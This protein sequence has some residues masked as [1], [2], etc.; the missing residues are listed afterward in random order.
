[1]LVSIVIPAINESKYIRRCLDAVM[2]QQL[3]GLTTEIVVVDGGSS[4]STREI[5]V[6]YGVRVLVQSRRGIAQARQM[7]FQAARG[8]IIA[9]TDADSEPPLDWLSRLVGELL[10]DSELVGVY[11]PIRLYDGKKYEDVLSHY[12]AGSYLYLN[13]VIQRPAFS[14]QNFAVWRDAW[15]QVGGFDVDWVSAEDVNLSLKLARIGKVKFC[16][17]IQVATSARRVREGYASVVRHTLTNYTRVTWLHKPP[18]PFVD[19]R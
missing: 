1:M 2:Q 4:D 6:E 9:S 18:L 17:D 3:P 14:G 8:A 10:A 19:I 15:E 13:A 16:W 12:V 7:G 11:G 5:A